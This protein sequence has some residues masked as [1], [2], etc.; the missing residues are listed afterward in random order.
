[1]QEYIMHVK[2][3]MHVLLYGI[4]EPVLVHIYELMCVLKLSTSYRNPYPYIFV[5]LVKL[6]EYLC[7]LISG[8]LISL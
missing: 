2:K 8:K 7:H 3:I 6:L 4:R 1:M 5:S